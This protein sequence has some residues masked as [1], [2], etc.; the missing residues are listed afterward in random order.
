[1]LECYHVGMVELLHDLQLPV[2]VSLVLI[3]L[4]DSYLLVVL[5]Y[6]CLEHHTEGAISNHT[7][8][9]IGKASGFLILLLSF[10]VCLFVHF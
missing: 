6:C 5:V 4:L 2:F 7:V 3:H 10:L 1:M 9:I 8:G